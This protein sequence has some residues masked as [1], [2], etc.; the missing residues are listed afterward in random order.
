MR[1]HYKFHEGGLKHLIA[2]NCRSM[3][4]CAN[5]HFLEARGGNP[6]RL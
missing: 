3:L 2:L 1:K 4:C 6:A 5:Y